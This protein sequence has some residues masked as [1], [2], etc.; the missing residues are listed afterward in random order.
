VI[1]KYIAFGRFMQV[2]GLDQSCVLEYA[3]EGGVQHR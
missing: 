2:L 3:A 1:G